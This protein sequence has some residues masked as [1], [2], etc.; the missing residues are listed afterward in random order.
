MTLRGQTRIGHT[1][2]IYRRKPHK[3]AVRTAGFFHPA[4]H[5]GV[6]LELADLLPREPSR[7]RVLVA[8]HHNGCTRLVHDADPVGALP[9]PDRVADDFV[10]LA[11]AKPG[12]LK[13]LAHGGAQRRLAIVDLRMPLGEAPHAGVAPFEQ[14]IVCF[15]V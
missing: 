5:V 6:R 7:H 11:G 1:L 15:A 9:E 12:L 8:A 10:I 2:Q 4:A 3:L 13:G 14:Q